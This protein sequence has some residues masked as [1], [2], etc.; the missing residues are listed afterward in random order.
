MACCTCCCENKGRVCCNSV[1]CQEAEYCCGTTCCPDAQVCCDDVCCDVDETCCGGECCADG[2]YCCGGVC[3][4]DPCEDCAVDGDCY[5]YLV[6]VSG[7]DNAG[8]G[9][10]YLY[11][12]FDNYADAAAYALPF[13]QDND[14]GAPNIDSITGICCDGVC[15]PDFGALP[16]FTNEES[17]S[18][19]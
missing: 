16:F 19:P 7:Y 4:E 15:Y 14:C 11:A 13:A 17:L 3:R 10:S 6:G 12:Y 1:C 5:Y 18:C 8:C 9:A 2:N